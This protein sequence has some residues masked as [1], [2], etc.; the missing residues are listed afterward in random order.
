MHYL[1]KIGV[2]MCL[3]FYKKNCMVCLSL[4]VLVENRC[5]FILYL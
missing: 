1:I 2:R 4:Y 5:L 3:R